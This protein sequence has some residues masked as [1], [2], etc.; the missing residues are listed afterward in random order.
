MHVKKRRRSG[1]RQGFLACAIGIADRSMYQLLI[2]RCT[3]LEKSNNSEF[4]INKI[5]RNRERDDEI[6]KRLLFEGWTVIRFWGDDI[7]KHTDECVK[8]VEEA[9]FDSVDLELL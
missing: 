5:S 9:I 6:N 4:W 7:K 8:V 2:I 3:R 1:L